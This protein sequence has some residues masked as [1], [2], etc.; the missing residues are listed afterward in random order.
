M[1]GKMIIEVKVSERDFIE[2]LLNNKCSG[3]DIQLI[4]MHLM[5][6]ALGIRMHVN[7][8]T[9]YMKLLEEAK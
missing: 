4:Q 7:D 5:F 9:Y 8:L 2:G 6:Y 1:Q 3:V